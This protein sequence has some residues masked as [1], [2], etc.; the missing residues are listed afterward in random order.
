M[1]DTFGNETIQLKQF[2]NKIKIGV[3]YK[4]LLDLDVLAFQNI[5]RTYTLRKILFEV[6]N[7]LNIG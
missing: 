2:L 4:Y 5:N 1:F 7:K 6:E 3:Q